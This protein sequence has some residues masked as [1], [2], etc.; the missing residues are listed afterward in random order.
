MVSVIVT[1]PSV[2]VVVLGGS[3][4]ED[5]G[6]V[7]V[8]SGDVEVDVE[9]EDVEVEP[10]DVVSDELDEDEELDELLS[11]LLVLLSD[12]DDES[13]VDVS[14]E[15]LGS[16]V[17]EIVTV[18]S[19]PVEVIV[20]VLVDSVSVDDPVEEDEEELPS[21]EL[22]DDESVDELA[23]DVVVSL[24]DV[25]E[26]EEALELLSELVSVLELL[27]SEPSPGE[28]TPPSEPVDGDVVD[29]AE[30]EPVAVL[31]TVQSGKDNVVDVQSGNSVD[32][33]EVVSSCRRPIAWPCLGVADAKGASEREMT[34]NGRSRLQSNFIS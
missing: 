22:L 27:L 23:V 16:V 21:D 6:D 34:T 15:L 9:V 11:L 10:D 19:E 33:V 30:L 3:V 28:F 31:S 25:A 14:E 24:A 26:D 8:E 17:V 2:P 5:G 18:L 4:V 13:L 7:V 20:P 29:S 32:V 1:R 12:E